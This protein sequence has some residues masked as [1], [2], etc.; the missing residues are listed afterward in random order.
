MINLPILD[1]PGSTFWSR[2]P[3]GDRCPLGPTG[4]E[5]VSS[6]CRVRVVLN[7]LST[8]FLEI[9]ISLFDVDSFLFVFLFFEWFYDQDVGFQAR[10]I[11]ILD[12]SNIQ[13]LD[14][15]CPKSKE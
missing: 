2:R 12:H 15:K 9:L 11:G 8:E 3:G 13:H 7:I 6:W 14:F 10:Q 4:A 1:H 5:L